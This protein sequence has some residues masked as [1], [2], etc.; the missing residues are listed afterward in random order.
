MKRLQC[1]GI[2]G[3]RGATA[4]RNRRGESD[5]REIDDVDS[6]R[7]KKSHRENG[8]L[9][10]TIKT[11]L[12]QIA[13]ERD[14]GFFERNAAAAVEVLQERREHSSVP[15]AYMFHVLSTWREQIVPISCTNPLLF[16]RTIRSHVRLV[17]RSLSACRFYHLSNMQLF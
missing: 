15:A 6:T 3:P 1:L 4:R 7:G 11:N 12:R 5:G 10:T 13:L 8:V 14:G 16:L 9:S 2:R 17:V